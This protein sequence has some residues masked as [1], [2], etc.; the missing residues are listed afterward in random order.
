MMIESLRVKVITHAMCETR[1]ILKLNPN[2]TFDCYAN[3][4]SSDHKYDIKLR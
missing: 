3:S 2:F 4:E 1:G